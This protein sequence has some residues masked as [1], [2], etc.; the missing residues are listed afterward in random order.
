MARNRSRHYH[1]HQPDLD[2][3]LSVY[4]LNPEEVLR[5]IL[6]GPDNTTTADTE[7]EEEPTKR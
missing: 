2:E 6:Q 4:P 1:R 7:E 5:R 3:P